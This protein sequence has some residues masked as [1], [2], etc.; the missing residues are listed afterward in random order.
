MFAA[1]GFPK[2]CGMMVE[3]TCYLV[4]DVVGPLRVMV[5]FRNRQI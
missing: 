3:I 5:F 2:V 4:A 1:L